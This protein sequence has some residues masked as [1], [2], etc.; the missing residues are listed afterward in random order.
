MLPKSSSRSFTNFYTKVSYKELLNAT[1]GFSSQNII[2]RGS[3]GTVYR[4]TLGS[5]RTLVAVKVFNPGREGSVKSFMSECRALKNIRHYNLVKVITACSSSDFQ[6][7][8][9]KAL[10]YQFM[11]NGSLDKWLHPGEE[12]DVLRMCNMSI[13]KR[14]DIAMDVASALH[15]LHHECQTPMVH[16]DLKPQNVLLDGDMMARVGDFGLARL[17]PRFD[18]Q[19]SSTGIKGTIGYAAPEHG[20]GAQMSILGDV[21]S[22]G[23][24]LLEMFTGKR[25]TDDLFTENSSL[26]SFVKTAVPDRV[27]EILDNSALSQEVTGNA[28]TW[29]EGWSCLSNKQRSCLVHVLQIGVTCSSVSPNDRMS[30][31]QVCR[32]LATIRDT[33]IDAQKQDK[34]SHP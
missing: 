30:M 29:E 32:E 16:C 26:H 19:L 22:F 6:G 12:G 18:E 4:G 24:L 25:P 31:R 5:D 2:G 21:Y 11:P 28:V 14:I 23:I 34:S 33:F 27:I 17:V 20:M 13:V 15:Y 10:V 1:N 7:N 9:F 3:F 8:D